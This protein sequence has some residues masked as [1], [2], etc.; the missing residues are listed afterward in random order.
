VKVEGHLSKDE[1]FGWSQVI[2]IGQHVTVIALLVIPIL[3]NVLPRF[4]GSKDKLVALCRSTFTLHGEA[5]PHT[6][7]KGRRKKKGKK[8]E[9]CFA[10]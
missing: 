9:R 2:A 1:N 4:H 6:N 3:T 8:R 7:G 5:S 10:M